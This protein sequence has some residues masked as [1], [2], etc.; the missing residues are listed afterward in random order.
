MGTRSFLAI[1]KKAHANRS[2]TVQEFL[3]KF[4]VWQYNHFDGYFSNAGQRIV[5]FLQKLVDAGQWDEFV[6]YL[7]NIEY[8]EEASDAFPE[9]DETTFKEMKKA[10]LEKYIQIE[11]F[12]LRETSDNKEVTKL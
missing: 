6:G 4:C 1:L 9:L 11:E 10:Y 7:D 12:P 5:D 2:K 3:D 8:A